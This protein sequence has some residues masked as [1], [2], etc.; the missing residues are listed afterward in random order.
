MVAP[1]LAKEQR[2]KEIESFAG[3]SWNRG[4]KSAAVD[5]KIRATSMIIIDLTNIIMYPL[6][7]LIY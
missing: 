5:P 2:A 3:L 6:L 7:Q 4:A 1:R